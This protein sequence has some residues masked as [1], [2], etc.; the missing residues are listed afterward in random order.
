MLVG[1]VV[2][3][4]QIVDTLK[5]C[6]HCLTIVFFFSDEFSFREHLNKVH[7]TITSFTTEV[8]SVRCDVCYD[9]DYRLINWLK[10]AGAGVNEFINLHKNQV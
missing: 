10:Q 4:N 7:K 1:L 8:F 5:Q 2:I 3:S 6:R 9:C